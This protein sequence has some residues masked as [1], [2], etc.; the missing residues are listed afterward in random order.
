MSNVKVSVVVPVYR[1]DQTLLKECIISIMHQTLP[2][3]EIVLVDDGAPAEN[4]HILDVY[5]GM[6]E[7]IRVI[8]QQ[9][10][11]VSAARNSGLAAAGGKYITFV[12]SDDHIAPDMLEQ[13]FA[14][15][16]ENELEIAIWGIYKCF[17][18]R[19]DEY[20]PFIQTIPL[21]HEDQK[22]D[23]ML[24]TMAGDLPIYGKLCTRC[25]SGACC[26]KLY[27]RS[28][29][30][31]EALS[32]PVGL[33]RSEDVNFNI[34]AFD[35]ADRIGYLHRFLYFYRQLSDSATY[36]YR[37]GGI[38][39]F[40]DALRELRRFLDENKKPELFY[41]VYYMR[42]IFFLLEG[43]NMDYLHPDNKKPLRQRLAELKKKMCEDPFA[44]AAE[45]IDGSYLTFPK[46]IPF[47]LTRHRLAA[48]MALFFSVYKKAETGFKRANQRNTPPA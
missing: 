9:N 11:G 4:A 35:K 22:R 42:C 41:Q 13:A 28:F 48:C 25:G 1:V 44:D 3:I 47:Y 18:D 8:H 38:S 23:L 32:Y 40:E 29:L 10:A 15:A 27:L 6:D 43:M 12:D 24:K 33:V 37:D 17:P 14:F 16:E 7:R 30:Q 2:E 45:R 21:L 19:R 46:K 26:A 39:V 36:Q 20:M 34:R 5:A 31:K